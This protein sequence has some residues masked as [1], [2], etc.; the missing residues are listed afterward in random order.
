METYVDDL[1]EAIRVIFE[2]D[3]LDVIQQYPLES[4]QSDFPGISLEEINYLIERNKYLHACDQD[5]EMI[6]FVQLGYQ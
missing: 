4:N 1:E 2:E 6:V 3:T 5:R